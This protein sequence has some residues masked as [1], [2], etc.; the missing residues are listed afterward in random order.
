MRREAKEKRPD[1]YYFA[2][3]RRKRAVSKTKLWTDGKKLEIT[4]NG[5]DFK[6]YFPVFDLQEAVLA[7]LRTVGLDGVSKVE[8]QVEGGGMRGQAEAVRLGISR[9]LLV[10]NADLRSSLKVEGFLT[11][12]PREK[13]R[14]KYGLKRARRAPQ[15][16]KR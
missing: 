3:G 6:E 12:D 13:E 10:F 11:R 4:V 9:A 8:A 7:P 1:G 15:W 5:R 16:S 14:K 2:V